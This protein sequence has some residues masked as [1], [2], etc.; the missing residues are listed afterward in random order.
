[1]YNITRYVS[2][3]DLLKTDWLS[4][5][6]V[7]QPLAHAWAEDNVFQN[8]LKRIAS[9]SSVQSLLI[10]LLV[11]CIYIYIYIYI[12]ICL[13]IMYI[14]IYICFTYRKNIYPLPKVPLAPSELSNNN[15]FD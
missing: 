13:H 8:M 3:G 12:Y 14:Y 6:A 11:L 7:T 9:R 2:I 5:Q 10:L 15:S 4:L 1:M